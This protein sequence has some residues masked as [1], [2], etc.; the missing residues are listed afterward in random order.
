M[1]SKTGRYP[2]IWRVFALLMIAVVGIVSTIASSSGGSGGTPP[3]ATITSPPNGFE[4][5]D[6]LVTVT[7]TASDETGIFRIQVNGVDA[8]SSD[9]FA[10][11]Q[12]VVPIVEGPNTLTVRA[13]D[14]LGFADSSADQVNVIL[15]PAPPLATV[16][17][18]PLNSFSDADSL[19][20]TGTATD[21]SGVAS[22]SVNGVDAEPLGPQGD[23]FATWRAVVPLTMN[24]ENTLTVATVDAV[25]FDDPAAAVVTVQVAADVSGSAVTFGDGYAVALDGNRAYV[26]DF[27]LDQLLEVNLDTGV[28]VV[29]SDAVTGGGRALSGPDGIAL[30]NG[31][32]TAL[33]SNYLPDELLS[34]DLVSGQRTIVSSAAANVGSGPT[35]FGPS[36]IGLVDVDRAI[37]S[38]LAADDILDVDLTSGNRAILSADGTRGSGPSFLQP[39]GIAMESSRR[40][41]VTDA[42]AV[43]VFAVDVSTGDRTVLSDAA[44]G[45]G[46]LFTRPVGITLNSD[47]S[48]ALVTDYDANLLISVT[49]S[50][51][52][53]RILSDAA[54][55]V[56]TGPAFIFPAGIALDAANNRAVVSGGNLIV[57]ELSSGDRVVVGP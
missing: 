7:G 19:T 24:T 22:V 2:R 26:V 35:L 30:I 14:T 37:V 39:D 51:G 42:L 47:N 29:I 10:T 38:N 17:F 23:E 43:A 34:I 40:A 50:N 16:T 6:D 49:V 52:F 53:R 18:P 20:V 46:P 56:G 45:S 54:T 11:W 28:K 13:V 31:G 4:T 9:R 5:E 41:L 25:G 57:V 27:D 36:G 8:T 1:L 33:V 21:R 15:T 32:T 55:D 12:A 44:T 3:M 48:R